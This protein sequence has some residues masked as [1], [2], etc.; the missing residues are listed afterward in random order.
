VGL[1]KWILENANPDLNWKNY[2]E[3]TILTVARERGN[4]ELQDL[5]R[6]HGAV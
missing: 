4:Q 5:L 6:A 3:K 2:E 1:A